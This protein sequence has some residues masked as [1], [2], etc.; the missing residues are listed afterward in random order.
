[1]TRDLFL[2][3]WLSSFAQSHYGPIERVAGILSLFSSRERRYVVKWRALL[4][5]DA[6]CSCQKGSDHQKGCACVNAG[7]CRAQRAKEKK[8]CC[9]AEVKK[10]KES[11]LQRG[12][13]AERV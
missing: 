9:E 11:K 1:M 3:G 13:R 8:R 6:L 7:K 4:V 2:A 12:G 5:V 10:R